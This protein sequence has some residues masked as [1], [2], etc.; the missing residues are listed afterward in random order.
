MEQP[1]KRRPHT[2]TRAARVSVVVPS[3]N[4]GRFLRA[5]VTSVLD[6]HGVDVDV[7]IIDDASTDET[8][9]VAAE[10]AEADPRVT[11]VRHET[12]AG[13]IATFNEGLAAAGGEYVVKLDADDLLTPGALERA[14]ALLDACPSVGFAYGHPIH[15]TGEGAPPAQYRQAPS[16]WEIWSGPSWVAE[17]CRRG[18]NCVSNPE[19]VVRRSLLDDVGLLDARL[20]HTFDLEM[21][22]RLASVADVGWIAGADQ[23]FYRIHGASFQ[24]TI[25][26]GILTD[27]RGRRDAFAAFFEGLG[28]NLPAAVEL[29]AA[30][31]RSMAADALDRVCRAYDRGRTA[32]VPVDDLVAFALQVWPEA[33]DLPGW[34]ALSR[35]RR[36]GPRLSAVAPPFVGRAVL[37]RVGEEFLARRWARSGV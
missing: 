29:D 18:V 15:F 26:A 13:H 17:R 14:A 6:Q 30:A 5:A 33:A 11:F 19:V 12:N 22:L 32:E 16:A 36:I 27:L 20:P 25:H 8:P 7:L 35:R 21:W 3:H 28:G 1:R 10:L 9:N 31:R 23:A 34:R 2:G 24:R 37:R 4:Y